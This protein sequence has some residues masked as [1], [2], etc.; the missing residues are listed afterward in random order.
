MKR[1]NKGPERKP[2][3]MNQKEMKSVKLKDIRN[4]KQ[5]NAQ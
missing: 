1:K 4:C 3:E 5:R 2:S